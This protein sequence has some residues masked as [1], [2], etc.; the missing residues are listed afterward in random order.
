MFI[1]TII[2][3]PMYHR[4]I[5]EDDNDKTNATN[6][7]SFEFK[8]RSTK[9]SRSRH[10]RNGSNSPP[11]LDPNRYDIIEHTIQPNE[12]L[13]GIA[14]RFN[15]S[16]SQLRLAN[17]IMSDQDFHILKVIRIPVIKHSFLIDTNVPI[18]DQQYDDQRTHFVDDLIDVKQEPSTTL[19]TKTQVINIGISNYLTRDNNNENYKQFLNNLST[20]LEEIRKFNQ[21]KIEENIIA[22]DNVDDV[23]AGTTASVSNESKASTY[24]DGSDFG[25]HWSPFVYS[26]QSRK[27]S[28]SSSSSLLIHYG[29]L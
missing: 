19:S 18:N 25:I 13:Q 5:N 8:N 29:Q 17:H 9:E 21:S 20:D 12:T 24:S 11:Y 28:P 15:C 10:S 27:S 7:E 23:A 22:T 2:Y 6:Y 3:H 1:S 4:L 14:L 16:I 26:I